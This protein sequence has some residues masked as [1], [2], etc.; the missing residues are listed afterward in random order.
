MVQ[1]KPLK[2]G[3]HNSRFLSVQ[4]VA[5][6]IAGVEVVHVGSTWA[7]AGAA[8]SITMRASP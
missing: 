6:E 8:V 5:L 7:V 2:T 3:P 1:T 4:L